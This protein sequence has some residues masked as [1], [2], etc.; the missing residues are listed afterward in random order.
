LLA[1]I[2]PDDWNLP[3]L[4]HVLG[5]VVLVGALVTA[6]SV[7][8]VGWRRQEPGAA[9]SYARL[10]FRTL[11]FVGLPA[12]FV[13]RIGAEWI[14]SKEGFGGGDNEPAW[15]GIGYITADLGGL[16]L[17]VSIILSGLGVR[18]LRRGDGETSVLARIATVLVALALLA[19]ILAVWAMS[20]KPD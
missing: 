6:L 10:A 15:L 20:G 3:L 5:A 1:A 2:R 16:L 18:R 17:L 13:M 12:W 9:T 4:V 8:L 19:Y 14:Y 7:Q 11:L